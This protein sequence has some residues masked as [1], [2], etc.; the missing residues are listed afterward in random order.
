MRVLTI[1]S[2]FKLLGGRNELNRGTV[3]P[4]F[5]TKLDV[6]C[7][8]IFRY[9]F[10]PVT[11]DEHECP[12]MTSDMNMRKRHSAML[13]HTMRL[14]NFCLVQHVWNVKTCHTKHVLTSYLSTSEG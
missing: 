3:W 6:S 2:Y 7:P 10:S 13:V 9:F 4:N 1:K 12:I 8:F 14:A 11:T 5:L